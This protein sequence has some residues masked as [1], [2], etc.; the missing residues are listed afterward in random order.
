M[1]PHSTALPPHV[2]CRAVGGELRVSSFERRVARRPDMRRRGKLFHLV[3]AFRRMPTHVRRRAW[4]GGGAPGGVVDVARHAPRVTAARLERQRADG[5]GREPGH[6]M[7]ATRNPALASHHPSS[8]ARASAAM[9]LPRTACPRKPQPASPARQEG[10]R[11]PGPHSLAPSPTPVPGARGQ[12]SVVCAS[13][14][15]CWVAGRTCRL[16]R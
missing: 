1:D 12:A 8:Q 13:F 9:S 3:D 14:S 10:T 2:R 16:L 15:S 6:G 7:A 4:I 5:R 11:T